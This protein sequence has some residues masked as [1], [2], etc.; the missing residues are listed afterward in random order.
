[1]FLNGLLKFKPGDARC[2]RRLLRRGVRG[3][4]GQAK[5]LLEQSGYTLP[6]P[7]GPKGSYVQSLRV[8]DMVYTAGHISV[9]GDGAI[10]SGKVTN[11]DAGRAAAEWCGLNILST[12]EKELGD[13]DNVKRVVKLTGFVNCHDDFVDHP[14]VLN[15]CSDLMTV[16]F[17]PIAGKHVRSA[18]GV[19]SLPLDCSVEVE[20][21]FEVKS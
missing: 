3:F 13:L 9:S 19:S 1:M 4:S 6:P 8:G 15:G 16:V 14:S 2:F 11:I 18:V 21:V 17:G 20:A 12:L 10:M 5:G 7:G